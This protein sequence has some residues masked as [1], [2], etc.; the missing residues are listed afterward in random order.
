[1]VPSEKYPVT[2]TS[3]DPSIATVSADGMITAK[4]VGDVTIIATIGP[5]NN[6]VSML[7]HV[8]AAPSELNWSD[9]A[10]KW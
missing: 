3:S 6:L 7:V 8:V 4:S 2:Y 9:S 1:M 10:Y 5:D